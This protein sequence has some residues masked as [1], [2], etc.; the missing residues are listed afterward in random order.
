MPLESGT[1]IS[2]L[3]AT[4]PVG[5]TDQKAEGDDHIRLL[6]ATIKNTFPNVTGAVTGTHTQLNSAAAAFGAS[7]VALLNAANTFSVSIS[8]PAFTVTSTITLPAASVADAALSSNVPLLN[9]AN[10]FTASQTIAH[11]SSPQITLTDTTTGVSVRALVQ[12]ALGVLGTSGAIPLYLQTDEANRIFIASD[13]SEIQFDVTLFDVNSNVD[14]SGTLTV[15][16]VEITPASG[17]FTGTLTGFG[18]DPTP[19]VYYDKVGPLVV[20][21]IA[22]DAF[23][24]SDASELILT[25]L[26]AAIQ[27]AKSVRVATDARDNGGSSKP[28]MAEIRDSEPDRVYFYLYNGTSYSVSAWTSSGSK[29]LSEGWTITYS[30]L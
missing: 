24:T 7:N 20:L 18:T 1:Y 30:V 16:S 22:A 9:A 5:A 25:G 29:G 26:P 27:P 10:T 2:D 17:S 21:H 4:N 6:K 28:A 14:I 11:A 3:V 15:G 8:V 23:G 19:T 12:D 13:G